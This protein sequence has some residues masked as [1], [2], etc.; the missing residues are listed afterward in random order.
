MLL[1]SNTCCLV[2]FRRRG[3]LLTQQGAFK[4]NTLTWNWIPFYLP[5]VTIDSTGSAKWMSWC[6]AFHGG[7]RS[8]CCF[9][10]K[11]SQME[12]GQIVSPGARAW[13][14]AS[15][16]DRRQKPVSASLYVQTCAKTHLVIRLFWR[17]PEAVVS[18]IRGSRVN[19]CLLYFQ[20][21]IHHRPYKKEA[22][23]MWVWN[24]PRACLRKRDQG[25]NSSVDFL[26]FFCSADKQHF[27]KQSAKTPQVTDEKRSSWFQNLRFLW[28]FVLQTLWAVPNAKIN[29]LAQSKLGKYCSRS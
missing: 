4:R 5:E 22:K 9:V 1:P 13:M 28:H 11:R 12:S 18:Q 26:A 10:W 2:F 3:V 6:L 25:K 8:A 7:W 14:G 17:V 24:K 23:T 19:P 15:T 16:G 27:Q 21:N 29:S 20:G